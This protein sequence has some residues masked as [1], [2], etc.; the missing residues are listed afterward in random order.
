MEKYIQ[1][2][3]TTESKYDAKR[4]ASALIEN[5]LAACVQV[6]GPILSVYRW[7][8]DIEKVQEWQ[9]V[10]KSRQDL[11]NKIDK[12]IQAVHSYKT[13]EIIATVISDGSEDYL[14]W[15]DEELAAS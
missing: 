10:I 14:K 6:V 12:A 11:F 2:V 4:I 8:G 7:K 5:K 9:C 13:P 15:L 1:V 3:T